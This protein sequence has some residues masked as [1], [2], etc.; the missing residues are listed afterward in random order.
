MQGAPTAGSLQ[1]ASPLVTSD[2]DP[3]AG[4]PLLEPLLYPARLSRTA[5]HFYRA[6]RS[7]ELPAA[8]VRVT[9][10]MWS[11]E[12]VGSFDA[13]PAAGAAGAAD[14][15][16]RV[17]VR[18]PQDDEEP[19]ARRYSFATGVGGP[20]FRVGDGVTLILRYAFGND[21]TLFA[22]VDDAAMLHLYD[23]RLT[24]AFVEFDADDRADE[25][26]R[27]RLRVDAHARAT[28]WRLLCKSS[29][30]VDVDFENAPVS[31]YG[32]MYAFLTETSTINAASSATTPIQFFRPVVRAPPRINL[33]QTAPRLTLETFFRYYAHQEHPLHA[34]V[35]IADYG[36]AVVD[37]AEHHP[38]IRGRILVV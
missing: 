7:R 11:I 37:V 26:R 1:P 30:S 28:V 8:E 34:A 33:A 6:D 27:G 13:A 16:Q 25:R 29:A 32:R 15:S 23:L 3:D 5:F 31:I 35:A 17:R 19:V 36:R 10:H 20:V 12:V 14:E 38:A 24:E 9:V 2:A 21:M 22:M 4:D 18:H